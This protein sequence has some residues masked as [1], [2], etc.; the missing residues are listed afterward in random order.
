[1]LIPSS[2]WRSQGII[3]A[4]CSTGYKDT[5]TWNSNNWVR[6]IFVVP[7]GGKEKKKKEMVD[8]FNG[9]ST[10]LGLFSALKFGNCVD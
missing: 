3:Q 2:S 6:Q 9:L 7:N 4:I 8:W 5:L 1:M 10:F